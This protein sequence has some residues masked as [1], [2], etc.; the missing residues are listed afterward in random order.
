[1]AASVISYQQVLDAARKTLNDDSKTRYPD[2]DLLLY[3]NDGV[4]AM[5]ELRSDLFTVVGDI[6]CAL[7]AIDQTIPAGGVALMDVFGIKNGGGISRT[8]L[9]TL[10]AFR[11]SWRTDPAGPAQN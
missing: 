4:K 7:G 11:P 3:L 6:P 1:M 2:A 10:R 9:D 8:D 5:V